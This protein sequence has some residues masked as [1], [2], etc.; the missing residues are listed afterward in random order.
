MRKFKEVSVT[1]EFELSVMEGWS[2]N[3]IM[4][5]LKRRMDS[6]VI[7]YASENNAST[8]RPTLRVE[9]SNVGYVSEEDDH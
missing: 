3:E 4:D 6:W 8:S 9:T 7:Q 2:L 5:T 1:V